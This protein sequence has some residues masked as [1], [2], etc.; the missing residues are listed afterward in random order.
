MR[1]R[2]GAGAGQPYEVADRFKAL[3]EEGLGL[4]TLSFIDIQ[5]IPVFG[6]EV[7][8]QLR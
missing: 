6:S 5:D 3:F 4:V 1:S 2:L 7:I 8:P